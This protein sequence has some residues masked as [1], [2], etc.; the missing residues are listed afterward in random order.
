MKYLF[1]IVIAS[2]ILLTPVFSESHPQTGSTLYM[3]LNLKKAYEN[4]T[5]SFSG[6]PGPDYWI[7]HSDYQIEARLDPPT[8]KL[9]GREIITYFNNSPDSLKQIVIRLYQDFFQKGNARNWP[10]DPVD[11]HDGV[12]IELL[13]VDGNKI[14][15]E[16]EEAQFSRSGTNLILNLTN[17]LAPQSNIILKINWNFIISSSV[18]LRMGTYDSTSFFIGLWYPQIAVYDDIDGWDRYS[19]QGIQE[20][21]NDHSNFDVKITMPA[22]FMVWATGILQNPS[23]LFSE[24]YLQRYNEAQHSDTVIRIITAEDLQK[25]EILTNAD[26]ATWH[27]KAANVPDFAFGTS[28]HYLWDASSLVIDEK[29]DRRVFIAAAYKEESEDFYEVSRIAR[30]SIHYFSTKLPGIP[31]PYPEMTV[32][33]GR[34]GMEF[35]MMCND[36]SASRRSSTVHLTSHEIFHTYFPFFMGTNERKYAWMDEGWA[37]ALP[38]E[39]Q[40]MLEPSYD[41]ITRNSK[42]YSR[43]AGHELEIPPMIPSIVVGG[44]TFRPSYR[45]AAYNRPGAAYWILKDVLGDSLFTTALREFINR[46]HY[47]HPVPYDFF[48]TFN[49]IAGENLDWFWKPW[50]FESGYPDLGIKDVFE[51]KDGY[52]VI[53]ERIGSIPVPVKITITYIDDSSET[54]YRTAKVWQNKNRGLTIKTGSD[55]E[56]KSIE[57]GDSQIP[58]VNSDNNIFYTK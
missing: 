41:P 23:E 8:R 27:F 1:I 16:A 39:L 37:T 30:Q 10:I 31:F 36:G 43:T 21:Y 5:R 29:N 24:F 47:K 9:S 45:T 32:F 17:P 12:E 44:N 58:D 49:E 4:G 19:Y 11:I 33:N 3:P 2:S 22:G 51:Q 55:K 54:I 15:L 20:F 35:P 42:S 34:G 13:E 52:H 38:F 26:S 14:D 50:F 28:D 46:W 40:H 7:N 25:G 56:I 48:F 53:I 6:K 57:L 18:N